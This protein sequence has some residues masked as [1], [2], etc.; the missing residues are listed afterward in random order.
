[1]L[2]EIVDSSLPRGVHSLCLNEW[3]EMRILCMFFETQTIFQLQVFYSIYCNGEWSGAP[4]YKK[5]LQWERCHQKHL[6]NSQR[7]KQ[8]CKGWG[9]LLLIYEWEIPAFPPWLI[10]EGPK[11]GDLV[12]D[13]FIRFFVIWFIWKEAN[14][15][16]WAGF[17]PWITRDVF[18]EWGKVSQC[19]G[20][21]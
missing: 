6:Q 4:W 3:V 14:L 2:S 18:T 8:S 20:C 10:C 16:S 9:K 5:Q 15:Y 7:G 12:V 11:Q 17:C 1:M 13:C 19:K 21:N